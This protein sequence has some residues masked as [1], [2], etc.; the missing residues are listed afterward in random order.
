MKKL[1][2][3]FAVAS[4]LTFAAC[5]NTNKTET[6]PEAEQQAPVETPAPAATD[7]VPAATVDSLPQN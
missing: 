4:A 6:S 1:V 5:S 3:F 2:L 7:T